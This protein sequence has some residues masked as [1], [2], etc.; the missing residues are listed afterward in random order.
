MSRILIVYGTSHGQTRKIAYRMA[1]MV[2]A[3][4]VNPVTRE[5]GRAGELHAAD[6]D[7]AIILA[8]LHAGGYQRGVTRWIEANAPALRTRPTAFVS[9]CLA[10]LEKDPAARH[11][12][13]AIAEQFVLRHAWRPGEIRIVAGA[14]PYTRYGWLTKLIMRRIAAKAGGDTDTTR[15]FEYTDW[16]AVEEFTT[17]FCHRSGLVA[18][19]SVAAGGQEGENGRRSWIANDLKHFSTS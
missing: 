5:A 11:Q 8:S 7:A 9:V 3:L 1:D 16:N 17:T 6:Y 12:A 15:D 4:G 2:A 10:I 19:Q 14:L 18:E 13:A